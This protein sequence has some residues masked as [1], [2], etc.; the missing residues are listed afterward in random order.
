MRLRRWVLLGCVYRGVSG[1]LYRVCSRDAECSDRARTFSSSSSGFLFFLSWRAE[2]TNERTNEKE[3]KE[4]R[5]QVARTRTRRVCKGFLSYFEPSFFF[6]IYFFLRSVLDDVRPLLVS[7]LAIQILTLMQKE[8][9][10]FLWFFFVFGIERRERERKELGT[11]LP[12]YLSGVSPQSN[13][14]CE[15]ITRRGC[16]TLFCSQLVFLIK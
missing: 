14:T 12:A 11:F 1:S 16:H 10:S 13:S 3:L 9:R 5:S 4:S 7:L 15:K 2:R 6:S 8:K